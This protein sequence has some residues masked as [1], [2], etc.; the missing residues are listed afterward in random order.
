MNRP[1]ALT[2]LAAGAAIGL[3]GLQPAV[4]GETFP[5]PAFNLEPAE[6]TVSGMSAGGYMAQQFHV[7]YSQRIAGAG[8]LAGGPYYCA[9]NSLAVALTRCMNQKQ[10]VVQA[11]DVDRLEWLTRQFAGYGVIDPVEGLAGDQ[12]WLFSSALD[13]TVHQIVVDALED[14]YRRFLDGAPLRHVRDVPAAHSMVTDGFG[15]PCDHEGSSSN[16][17][18]HFINDCGFDAAGEL[19]QHL[20][21]RMR[22][23]S[24]EAAPDG[25]LMAFDQ[26]EFIPDPRSHSMDETGY[27]YVPRVCEQGGRCRLHVVFHGCLQGAERIGET[28]VR[29]SGYNRWADANRIVVLYP[30]ATAAPSQGNGNGCW[31]WWGYDDADYPLREGR[32]M[33]AVASM[34]DR[35]AAA[36]DPD[37]RPLP[38]PAGLTVSLTLDGRLHLDWEPVLDPAVEGYLVFRAETPGG[39]SLAVQ[40]TTAVETGLDLDSLTPGEHHFVIVAVDG[41]GVEGLPT[42][43]LAVTVPGL[44]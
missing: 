16:P 39:P 4:A 9:E 1:R 7:A 32:Q 20:Y 41:L 42:P 28:F 5:L 36:S 18:D 17:D 25:R 38:A 33:R 43:A 13:N 26:S 44:F 22:P 11:P 3:L 19:L 34:I 24:P 29:H 40:A 15:F 14:Y 21:R 12:V 30:Q 35:L 23:P 8:I 2:T 10:V 37:H 27:A 31:D 6:T